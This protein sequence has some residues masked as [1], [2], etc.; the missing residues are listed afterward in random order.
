MDILYIFLCEMKS[1][2]YNNIMFSTCINLYK[3]DAI[4]KF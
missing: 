1:I 2:L 4:Y 3:T